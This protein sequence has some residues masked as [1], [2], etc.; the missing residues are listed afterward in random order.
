MD[1]PQDEYTAALRGHSL[2]RALHLPELVARRYGRLGS[3][4]GLLLAGIA[5][6][7]EAHQRAAPHMIDQD[8]A[9]DAEQIMAAIVDAGPIL[10]PIGADQRFGHE[11]VDIGLACRTPPQPCAQGAL[12]RQDAGL[13]P[14]YALLDF[15]HAVFPK[16]A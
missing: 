16:N 9:G 15:D 14:I 2:D 3:A 4:V 6:T 10:R 11:I 13:E 1:P 5:Q 7:V 8:V 12:V